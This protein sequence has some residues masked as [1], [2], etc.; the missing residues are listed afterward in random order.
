MTKAL[1]LTNKTNKSG[2]NEKKLL[3]DNEEVRRMSTKGTGKKKNAG[4]NIFCDGRMTVDEA[5]RV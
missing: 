4:R 1:L 2:K 3:K 5:E